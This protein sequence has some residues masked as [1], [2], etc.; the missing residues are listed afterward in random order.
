MTRYYLIKIFYN[1]IAQAEDRPQPTA[2]NSLDEARKALNQYM[3]QSILGETCGW[4]LAMI[5]NQ[6]GG[7]EMRDYWEAYVE[8]APEPAEEG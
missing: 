2:Y 8:P 1:K 3:G 6:H 5:I 4:V 7:T